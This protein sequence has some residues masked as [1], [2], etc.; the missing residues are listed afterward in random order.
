VPTLEDMAGTEIADISDLADIV[1]PLDRKIFKLYTMA[2]ERNVHR[3]IVRR[4]PNAAEPVEVR[5][6]RRSFEDALF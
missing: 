4:N 5:V 6:K 1:A 3:D 2:Q